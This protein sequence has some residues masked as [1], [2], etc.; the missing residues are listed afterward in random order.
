MNGAIF[1]LSLKNVVRGRSRVMLCI[2]SVAVGIAALLLLYCVGSGGEKAVTDMLEGFGFSGSLIVPNNGIGQASP[3]YAEDAEYVLATVRGV[4]YAIAFTTRYGVVRSDKYSDD[5]VIWGVGQGMENFIDFTLLYGN[6]LSSSDVRE[7]RSLCVIDRDTA[8]RFFG[9]ENAVGC[10]LTVGCGSASEEFEIAAVTEGGM[11][12]LAGLTGG[13]SPLFVYIPGKALTRLTGEK[14]VAQLAVRTDDADSTAVTE[15]ICRALNAKYDDSVGYTVQD[16]DG[17]M[18]D[19][20]VVMQLLRLILLAAASISLV[21]SGI[22]V[23]N[24]MFSS[25]SE[26]RREIGLCL[27]VGASPA[28][29]CAG[30]LAEA[31]LITLFG[32]LIGTG[33][34]LLLSWPVAN[35][36]GISFMPNAGL[37]LAV[38][39]FVVILGLIFGTFPALKASRLIPAET[40]RE[41]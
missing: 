6:F 36:L 22:G 5:A 15:R 32:G 30:F 8:F 12:V 20:S 1:R 16:L 38:V 3:L 35:L 26:R 31:M 33:A 19:V 29:I 37:I 18:G 4:E 14:K 27:A 7:G 11:S 13:A 39:G 9:R 41:E 25:V 34:G 40:L 2:L 24:A 17:Y 21:V 10:F 28:Q 23:M